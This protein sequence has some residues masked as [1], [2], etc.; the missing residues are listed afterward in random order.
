MVKFVRINKSFFFFNSPTS[1]FFFIR[2]F[3]I[4]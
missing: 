1:F 3:P 2:Y 4:N